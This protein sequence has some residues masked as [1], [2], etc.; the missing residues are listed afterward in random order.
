M[1][2]S[3][4]KEFNSGHQQ[5]ATGR[6]SRG[7]SSAAL[8][9]ALTCSAIVAPLFFV[10]G[11]RAG[12][13]GRKAEDDSR[14]AQAQAEASLE[15]Q[16]DAGNTA[17]ELERLK[18]ALEKE[19]ENRAAERAGRIRAERKA[20]VAMQQQAA[21]VG[22]Q[23]IPIG[24]AHTCFPGRNGTPRQGGLCPNTR[25]Y[26]ELDKELQPAC[27]EKLDGFSH[28]WVVYVFHENT[29]L[30]NAVVARS[31]QAGPSRN[32]SE[33]SS[34]VD[35][36]SQSK[37]QPKARKKQKQASRAKFCKFRPRVVPPQ[38]AGVRVGVFSTRTPHRP[39]PIGLVLCRIQ[40]VDAPKRRVYLSGV[41]L[42]NGTPVLDL[43]P[44]L[45]TVDQV[46]A[47]SLRMPSWIASNKDFK[48]RRVD[49]APGVA[50]CIQ[51]FCLEGRLRHFPATDLHVAT[52][53]TLKPQTEDIDSASIIDQ[54][55]IFDC[56]REVLRL[57]IR[58]LHQGR[59][60]VRAC[61]SVAHVILRCVK[62]CEVECTV[63]AVASPA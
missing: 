52:R 23:L 53:D 56:I 3:S 37:T 26:I 7:R 45:A 27:L 11:L 55:P 35:G 21:A 22:Y 15:T 50:Q 39:N 41:D 18:R 48:P 29:N 1:L 51:S 25:G 6:V 14:D 31:E 36:A 47:A 49:F 8:A 42:V 40:H 58:S 59:G 19:E 10:L 34:S 46:P 43:K 62:W 4:V 32:T 61:I 16:A 30:H 33:G 44:Y 28:V 2:R 20:R 24:I 12:K 60:R 57:D 17:E 38:L 13:K 54:G 63:F 9:I 5:L